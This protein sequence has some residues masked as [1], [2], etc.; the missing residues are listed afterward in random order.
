MIAEGSEAR[1]RDYVASVDLLIKADKMPRSESFQ[2]RANLAGRAAD[3]IAS[4]QQLADARYGLAL[5]MGLGPTEG[6]QIPPPADS[7]PEVERQPVPDSPASI[8][9]YID[10]AL[11][12]RAD[13]LAAEKR[14][15]AADILRIAATNGVLP[16]LD[17]LMSA[18]YRGSRRAAPP[19]ITSAPC[20]GAPAVLT[21]W[22]GFAGHDPSPTTPPKVN[23]PRRTRSY[24]QAVLLAY[25]K[26]RNVSSE[27]SSA[28]SGVYHSVRRLAQAREAVTLYEAALEG[29]KD[30]LRLAAGSLT[31]LLTVEGRMTSALVDLVAAQEAYA[32]A[33][34]QLRH[35]TGTL[36][37]ADGP[38]TSIDR[39]VFFSPPPLKLPE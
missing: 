34:V 38:V 27:V 15:Q 28:I 21:C 23:S 12:N 6:L 5:A 11:A 18:G 13:C 32:I 26:E 22:S 3:R 8:R 20:T 30:K 33:L 2:V 24:R 16:K 4:E 36:V 39:D 31:D 35:A 14:K 1:A 9:P 19:G 10:L 25:D 17:V 37:P 29:E 7:F